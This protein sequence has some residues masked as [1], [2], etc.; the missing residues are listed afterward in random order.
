M[1]IEIDETQCYAVL[2]LFAFLAFMIVVCIVMCIL[3]IVNQFIPIF[4]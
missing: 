4:P 3:V 1:K 2:P